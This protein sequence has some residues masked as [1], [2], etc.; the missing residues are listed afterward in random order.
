MF[1]IILFIIT[2]LFFYTLG[3]DNGIN[4]TAKKVAEKIEESKSLDDLKTRL[5]INNL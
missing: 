2:A 1:K 3:N 4:Y 5:N